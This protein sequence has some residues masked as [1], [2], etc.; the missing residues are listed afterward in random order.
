MGTHDDSNSDGGEEDRR[1]EAASRTQ[2]IDEVLEYRYERLH[3]DGEVENRTKEGQAIRVPIPDPAYHNLKTQLLK[4]IVK[5]DDL[6]EAVGSLDFKNRHGNEQ[7]LESHDADFVTPDGELPPPDDAL[8]SFGQKF[9]VNDYARTLLLANLFK[10]ESPNSIAKSSGEESGKY[11][12]ELNLSNPLSQP[13]LSRYQDGV[14]SLFQ[15]YFSR[16]RTT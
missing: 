9:S 3:G 11:D 7:V 12:G 13:T 15:P 5:H 2:T 14:E 16:Y 6:A 8:P 4:N 10:D 1:R